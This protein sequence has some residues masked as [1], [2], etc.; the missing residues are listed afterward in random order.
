MR[1]DVQDDLQGGRERANH[2]WRHSHHLH[3]HQRSSDTT[4][5]VLEDKKNVT[6]TRLQSPGAGG[7]SNKP[8]RGSL[9]DLLEGGTRIPAFVSNLDKVFQ[10]INNL[11]FF[12]SLQNYL[13]NRLPGQWR[14][15]STL[16]TGSPQLCK[17]LQGVR[18]VSHS[19]YIL[20]LSLPALVGELVIT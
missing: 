3:L 10:K 11:F 9:G 15:S 12:L 20:P 4:G 16:Q 5:A 8:L 2:L 1:W 18:S 14:A 13:S 19:L 7:G 6:K 17:E